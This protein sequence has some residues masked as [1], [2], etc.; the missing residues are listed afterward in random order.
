[1]C[2]AQRTNGPAICNLKRQ[3]KH[4]LCS[5][6]SP[7]V[8]GCGAALL[9]ND[10]KDERGIRPRAV[11]KAKTSKADMRNRRP[12]NVCVS[13]KYTLIKRCGGG[14]RLR[15]AGFHR[16]FHQ[17]CL[18]TVHSEARKWHTGCVVVVLHEAEWRSEESQ[19]ESPASI[20]FQESGESL[21]CV[22]HT[23]TW[24]SQKQRGMLG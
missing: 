5:S 20:W 17:E 11:S 7:Q 2:S 18:Q 21:V 1:M 3:G 14:G 13:R 19:W 22:S 4:H 9:T 23:C 6:S 12:A 15:N 10:S 8:C 16:A 24:Q